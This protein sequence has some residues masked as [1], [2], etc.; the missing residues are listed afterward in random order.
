MTSSA[1]PAYYY[2]F[3]QLYEFHFSVPP[4]SAWADNNH[5]SVLHALPARLRGRILD[6]GGGIGRLSRVLA[7]RFPESD[8]LSIDSSAA[9]TER[10]QEE[11]PVA[12]LR[13][14]TRSFWDMTGQYDLIVCA[15]C[16]EF[17][18]LGPSV[19]HLARLMAPGGVAVLN[20]LGP[21]AFGR[22]RETVF[23]HAWR[24]HL[25]LHPP[26][27]L[28]HRLSLYGTDVT[29]TPVNRWEGSYT[30]VARRQG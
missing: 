27:T 17:F 20:T 7:E 9:M 18:Q 21:S 15:G 22:V 3:A 4:F 29:W 19:A 26:E 24:T 12:N 1:G 2:R 11:G 6:V 14:E 28:A 30:L 16:W 13:F 8:V 25:W 23:R 5:A 10:A